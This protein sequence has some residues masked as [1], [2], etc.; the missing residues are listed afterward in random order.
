MARKWI[1]FPLLVI[2][3]FALS[4]PSFA[5]AEDCNNLYVYYPTQASDKGWVVTEIYRIYGDMQRTPGKLHIKGAFSSGARCV[6]VFKKKGGGPQD[7]AVYT[8]NQNWCAFAAG[9]ISVELTKG[10]P[11]IL[12]IGK[13]HGS[14]P[15]RPGQVFLVYKK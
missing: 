12:R 14:F 6:M 15:N 3:A 4:L 10:G 8:I 7:R 5:L 2:S 9:N 13:N 11:A 1:A